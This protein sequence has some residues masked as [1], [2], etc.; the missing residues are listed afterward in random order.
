MEVS[1]VHLLP[2]ASRRHRMRSGRRRARLWAL[3]RLAM[4]CCRAS[5]SVYVL[6]ASISA[7]TATSAS[8]MA[9]SSCR[10]SRNIHGTISRVADTA[11][12]FEQFKMAEEARRKYLATG[13]KAA[14]D[15]REHRAGAAS[16]RPTCIEAS[17][18]FRPARCP[19]RDLGDGAARALY[20][21]RARIGEEPA[22]KPGCPT[23]AGE[24]PGLGMTTAAKPPLSPSP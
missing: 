11:M 14:A 17:H 24:E 8:A 1:P 22:A 20:F 7:A 13:W 16:L 4:Y 3:V 15:Q 23:E 10:P 2:A 9:T 18:V 5:T 19:R 6:A 12:L 21:A